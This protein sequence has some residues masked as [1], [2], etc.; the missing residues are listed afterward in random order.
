MI[1]Q[2]HIARP[3]NRRSSPPSVGTDSLVAVL[4]GVGLASMVVWQY[5]SS[6]PPADP[7]PTPAP[8]PADHRVAADKRDQ[9]RQLAEQAVADYY[10]R[11]AV[12]DYYSRARPPRSTESAVLPPG[13]FVSGPIPQP[14]E[15]TAQQRAEAAIAIYQRPRPHE[16]SVRVITPPPAPRLVAKDAHPGESL[17]CYHLRKRREELNRAATR[18]STQRIRDELTRNAKR[19]AVLRCGR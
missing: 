10:A 7:L 12:A 11:G 13:S 19:Y 2:D 4:V 18:A 9:A 14:G 17:D 1:P 3:R 6:Q 8:S 15:P 5:L 16:R